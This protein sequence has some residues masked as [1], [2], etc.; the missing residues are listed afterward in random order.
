[1]LGIRSNEENADISYKCVTL[2]VDNEVIL[3]QY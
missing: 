2:T 1:M 3:E